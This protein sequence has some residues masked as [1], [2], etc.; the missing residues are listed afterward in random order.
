MIR[1]AL[2]LALALSAGASAQSD[3]TAVADEA[4]APVYPAPVYPLVGARYGMTAIC[5]A[6]YNVSADGRVVD[7]CTACTVGEF[8]NPPRSAINRATRKFAEA[9]EEALQQWR[10]D[11]ANWGDRGVET[12]FQ[13]FMPQG[14]PGRLPD[15]PTLDQCPGSQTP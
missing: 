11:E 8:Y 10:Y 6:S 4:M 13:F 7:I 9:T 1:A 15:P 3:G 2:I 14:I 12:E 5:R